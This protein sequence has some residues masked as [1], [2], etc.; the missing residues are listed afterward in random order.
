MVKQIKVERQ[1]AFDV[2]ALGLF[3]GIGLPG[4]LGGVV[5]GGEGDEVLFCTLQN[6]LS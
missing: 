1:E 5:E 2:P 4:D 3:G 6:Y